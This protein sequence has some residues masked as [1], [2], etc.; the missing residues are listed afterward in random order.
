ML[1]QLVRSLLRRSHFSLA[2]AARGRTLRSSLA[3]ALDAAS[4]RRRASAF[5]SWSYRHLTFGGNPLH[6]SGHCAERH[7]HFSANVS[8]LPYSHQVQKAAAFQIV[9]TAAS[10]PEM[11][12][13]PPARQRKK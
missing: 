12:V 8:R 3:A 4:D 11:R 5:D 13:R 9:V 2:V 7:E 10:K 6:Q 1:L